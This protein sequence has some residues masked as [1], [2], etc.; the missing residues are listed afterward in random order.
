LQEQLSDAFRYSVSIQNTSG[1]IEHLPLHF[2][3]WSNEFDESVRYDHWWQ[4][5]VKKVNSFILK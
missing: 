5:S 3:I 2:T 1:S 4:R